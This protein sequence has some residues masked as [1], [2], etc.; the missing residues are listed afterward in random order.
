MIM[1]KLLTQLLLSI[2]LLSFFAV[3]VSA[4]VG[5]KASLTIEIV[6]APMNHYYVALLTK[7]EFGP[8][9]WISAVNI[10][11][12]DEETKTAS[13]AFV[14]YQDKDGYKTLSHVQECSENNVFSW[15]YYP[16]NEFKIAIYNVADGS[17][18]VSDAFKKQ[19]FDAK[20]IVEYGPELKVEEVD[21]TASNIGRFLL[22]ALITT[23]VEVL[24]G[25]LFGYREKKQIIVIVVTNLITQILLNLFMA[26]ADVSMGGYAWLILFPIGEGIVWLIELIVYLIAIK[27]KPKWLIPIYTTLANGLTFVAGVIWGL[28]Y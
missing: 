1:K 25:L 14:N 19:A 2:A 8:Y 28:I 23:V 13:E 6:N 20:F 17:L 9:Q 15:T 4:D 5:P 10:N 24:L 16:P 3:P 27:K 7:E 12:A 21:Q 26:I 18:K 11:V 22:R